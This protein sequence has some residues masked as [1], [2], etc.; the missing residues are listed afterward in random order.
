VDDASVKANMQSDAAAVES[1]ALVLRLWLG[2]KRVPHIV[3]D[4][5]VP[6]D[7]PDGHYE[8]FLY[9]M[10]QFSKLF[11]GWFEV[12]DPQ[13]LEK[14][15]ALCGTPLFLNVASRRESPS[16]PKTTSPE[17]LVEAELVKSPQFREHFG[18]KQVDRQFPVGLFAGKVAA[19]T[20]IFT[21]GKSAIDIVGVGKDDRFWIFELKAGNNF[22]VG[23]LSEL[24]LYTS[25]IRVAAQTPPRIHFATPKHV[26]AV[27]PEHVRNCTGINAVMLVENLHPLLEHPELLN[28]LNQAA[29]TWWNSEPKQFASPARESITNCWS[30][31]SKWPLRP[32]FECCHTD[33]P[34]RHQ[35]DRR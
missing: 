6:S 27:G 31:T 10:H 21:G 15:R 30:A 22:K 16:P 20:R 7:G 33:R 19:D 28:T 4:W 13:K 26:A 14:C 5:N 12:A 29:K 34:P 25:L 35:T 18:L 3:V 23:I 2:G 9:R 24:L 1:W 17:Y 11:P 8:R 32:M